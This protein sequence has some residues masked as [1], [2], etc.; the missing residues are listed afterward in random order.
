MTSIQKAV[1]SDRNA[2]RKAA[3]TGRSPDWSHPVTEVDP[4]LTCQGICRRRSQGG[5]PYRHRLGVG[6][7]QGATNDVRD[8]RADAEALA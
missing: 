5:V 8:L 6:I 1:S 7:E 4:E 3:L 2:A